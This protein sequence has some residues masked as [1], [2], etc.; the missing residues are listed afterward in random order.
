ME[1]A[2]TRSSR[3]RFKEGERLTSSSGAATGGEEQA[4]HR[5]QVRDAG[6]GRP[7]SELDQLRSQATRWGSGEQDQLL[8]L[9]PR[10]FA[11]SLFHPLGCLSVSLD[12]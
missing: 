1:L 4:A 7:V 5:G 3:H 8:N 6:S 9:Q 12:L 11:P 2:R 10:L